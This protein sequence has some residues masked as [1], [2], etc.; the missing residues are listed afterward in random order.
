MV[1]DCCCELLQTSVCEVC[2]PQCQLLPTYM[3]AVPV[4]ADGL[5][6][7]SLIP[8]IGHGVDIERADIDIRSIDGL[9]DTR[10]CTLVAARERGCGSERVRCVGDDRDLF[11]L[12]TDLRRGGDLTRELTVGAALLTFFLK[13]LACCRSGDRPL[14]M[15]HLL[16]GLAVVVVR[17]L[18]RPSHGGSIR[19]RAI[20]SHTKHGIPERFGYILLVLDTPLDLLT[21]RRNHVGI[22]SRE[23]LLDSESL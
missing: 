21:L 5:I 1:C 22:G 13:L 23:I 9:F 14:P 11:V 20:G 3:L 19:I 8:T 17:V 7:Q 10:G 4:E 16:D 15:L 12:R 2:L 6:T 18:V